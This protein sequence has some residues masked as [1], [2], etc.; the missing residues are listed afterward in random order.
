MS[1]VTIKQFLEAGVHFG[2]QTHRWNPKMQKYIFGA[3]NGIHIINLEITLSCLQNVL[4][5]MKKFGSEGKEVLFVGT[6]KQAQD[7]IRE[8]A[9][10]CEMPYVNERWLGGMLTNFDTIRKS[11]GKLES[12]DKMEEEG[13][14]RFITKKEGG[15]LRKQREKLN[16][17]LMGIRNMRRLPAAIFVVDS[18]KEDIAIR[19]AHKLGIP[20][21]AI[22]DSNSD[23]DL[24]DHPIPG[25]DDAIRAVKLFCDTLAEAIRDGRMEYKKIV[26]EEEA[27]RAKEEAEAAIVAAEEA[28]AK[29]A[30]DEAKKIEAAEK[31]ATAAA[32][33]APSAVSETPEA[34]KARPAK[35]EPSKTST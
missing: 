26:A 6:K 21:I 27:E 23:P 16:K 15:R 25:N 31:V 24:V 5:L 11:L 28:A 19:E 13:G 8:A 34:P 14:F 1:K 10:G 2:H 4:V 30:D 32:V 33:Q 17:N 3:R 20:V 7:S 35:K 29:A 12:I 22:L 9:N 18:I